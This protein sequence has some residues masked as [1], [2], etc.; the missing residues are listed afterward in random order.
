VAA[1]ANLPATRKASLNLSQAE[2]EEDS[3]SALMMASDTIIELE[4]LHT[5][6]HSGVQH[7]F[8]N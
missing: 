2:P 4:P 7:V 8:L 6:D 5:V 1:A 3:S